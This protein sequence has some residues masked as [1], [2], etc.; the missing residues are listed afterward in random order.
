MW[1]Q[2]KQ[3]LTD[4]EIKHIEELIEY[5]KIH[6]MSL[7][8]QKDN[9]IHVNPYELEKEKRFLDRLYQE[10]SGLEWIEQTNLY[11]II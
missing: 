8:M 6:V 5:Q 9:G 3:P 10:L 2:K 4:N 7:L 1:V 11:H